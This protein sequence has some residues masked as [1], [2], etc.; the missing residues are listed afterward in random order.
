M[1]PLAVSAYGTEQALL[2]TGNGNGGLDCILAVGLSAI[3]VITIICVIVSS[4]RTLYSPSDFNSGYVQ[5]SKHYLSLY[6]LEMSRHFQTSTVNSNYQLT[7]YIHVRRVLA[8]N[9][10]IAKK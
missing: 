4:Y 9:L 3:T 8:N 2:L 7:N 10:P 5:I 6:L 1:D